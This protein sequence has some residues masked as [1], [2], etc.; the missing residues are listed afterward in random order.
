MLKHLEQQCLALTA[1]DKKTKMK[2]V[3][4]PWYR[5]DDIETYFVKADKLE[6]DLQDNYGIEWSTSIKITQVEDEMY[7][8][9]M[10]AK[11]ELMTWEE[12]PMA[13]K[14]WFHLQTHFKDRWSAT[15]Q[16]QVDTPHKHGF[17]SSARAEE[18]RDEQ[19]G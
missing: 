8:S 4:I 3:N 18:D 10:F 17:E 1:R 9:N 15:M 5:D 14:T 7:R 16:Y 12:K 19:T 6:E 13:N 11:E 2:D